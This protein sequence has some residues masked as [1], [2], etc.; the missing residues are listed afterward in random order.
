VRRAVEQRFS[1]ARMAGDYV[2]LYRR[3]IAAAQP[4]APVTLAISPES[5]G[6][7]DAPAAMADLAPMNGGTP[8]DEAPANG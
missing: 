6:A 3:L 2:A 8:R 4:N 1:Q 7:V 5:S